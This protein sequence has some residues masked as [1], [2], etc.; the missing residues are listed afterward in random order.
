ME[1]KQQLPTAETVLRLDEIQK[2]F[3]CSYHSALKIHNY[4]INFL[5]KQAE[6]IMEKADI[7]KNGFLTGENAMFNPTIVDK[8]SILTASEEFIKN[9]K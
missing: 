6:V 7:T 3:N 5:R 4:N 8:Q 1:N 2:H 9:L